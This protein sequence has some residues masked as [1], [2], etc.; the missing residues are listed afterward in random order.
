MDLDRADEISKEIDEWREKEILLKSFLK[1][2]E[3]SKE[4][5][6]LK[7]ANQERLTNFEDNWEEIIMELTETSQNI[8]NALI[9]QHKNETEMLEEEINNTNL[10]PTK[11]TAELLNEKFKLKKLVKSRNYEEAKIIQKLIQKRSEE[12]TEEWKFKFF[13]FIEKKREKLLKNQTSEY[14]GLKS[15]IERSIN[16]KLK[17]KTKSQEKLMLL[18]QNM[19]NELNNKQNIEFTKLQAINSKI[20]TKH[21]LNWNNLDVYNRDKSFIEKSNFS[22]QENKKPFLKNK[23]PYVQTKNRNIQRKNKSNKKVFGSS[24]INKKTNLRKKLNTRGNKNA[25]KKQINLNLNK[26]K[27]VEKKLSQKSI[28]KLTEPEIEK[29]S[30]FIEKLEVEEKKKEMKPD[31]KKRLNFGNIN[32]DESESEDSEDESGSD[33]DYSDEDE[34]EDEEVSYQFNAFKNK[35]RFSRQINPVN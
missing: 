29:S 12:E 6:N 22:Q 1:M 27:N 26:K 24:N 34:D 18:I 32:Q 4:L 7:I 11:F 15:R 13:N 19:E 17:E 33:S 10:P 35:K 8:E 20:L 2:S 14:E 25:A 16:S 3:N 30:Q 5:E 23:T 9:E 21:S 28:I 31:L